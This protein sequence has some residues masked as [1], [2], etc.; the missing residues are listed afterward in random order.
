M[1]TPRYNDRWE[2]EFK[3]DMYWETRTWLTIIGLWKKYFE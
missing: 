2:V 3:K 1:N